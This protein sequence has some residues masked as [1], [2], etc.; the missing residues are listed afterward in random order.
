MESNNM[1]SLTIYDHEL[2]LKNPMFKSSVALA[3]N[4]DKEKMRLGLKFYRLVIY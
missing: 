4:Y 3:L 1:P 2:V